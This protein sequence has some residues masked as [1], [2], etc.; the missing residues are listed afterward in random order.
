MLEAALVLM[1]LPPI[2]FGG[3]YEIYGLLFLVALY[4]SRTAS[5]STRL[6]L[7]ALAAC[8]FALGTTGLL[9]AIRSYTRIWAGWACTGFSASLVVFGVWMFVSPGLSYEPGWQFIVGPMFFLPGLT[10][11]VAGMVVQFQLRRVHNSTDIAQT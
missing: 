10:G 3:V 5:L 6:Q 2:A 11:S 4:R 8:C 1:R 7:V 9:A